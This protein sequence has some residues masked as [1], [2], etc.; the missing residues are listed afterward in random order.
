MTKPAINPDGDD[1]T[2]V[3]GEPWLRRNL[4]LVL[5]A[6][7]VA[8]ASVALVA[9]VGWALALLVVSVGLVGLALVV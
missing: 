6:V 7:G 5:A 2:V 1:S 4:D 3:G 9:L 8:G